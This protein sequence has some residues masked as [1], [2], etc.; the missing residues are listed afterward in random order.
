MYV[1]MEDTVRVQIGDAKKNTAK[2]SFCRPERKPRAHKPAW[3]MFPIFSM[4]S[5]MSET[6]GPRA[7]NTK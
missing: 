6:G 4:D 3:S 5:N 1:S 7:S 2:D